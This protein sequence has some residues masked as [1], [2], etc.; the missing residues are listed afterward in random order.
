[1]NAHDLKAEMLTHMLYR[2]KFDAAI[3]EYGGRGTIGN[4]DVFGILPS[5]F[6]HEFEVKVSKA[7]LAGELRAI[8]YWKKPEDLRTPLFEEGKKIVPLSKGGKHHIY[9]RGDRDVYTGI[10]SRVPNKFSF[11]VPENLVRYAEAALA[12]TPYGLF[13]V[14]IHENG[15]HPYADVGC[16][17]KAGYLHKEK[18]HDEIA[19]NILRKACTEI[20]VL[21]RQ[22]AKGKRCTKCYSPLPGRCEKCELS[23]KRDRDYRRRQNQCWKE[24]EQSGETFQVCMARKEAEEKI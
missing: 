2:L 22:A 13:M 19:A 20:E 21:R 15:G 1:M 17:K 3:T 14:D 4:A 10:F 24:I 18:A 9:L 16:I 7:D 23:I 6:T 12:D 5:G 8:E 11:V